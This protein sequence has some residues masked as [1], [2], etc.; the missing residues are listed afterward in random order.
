MAAIFTNFTM[1][2]SLLQLFKYS[3]RIHKDSTFLLSKTEGS[4]KFAKRLGDLAK[5]LEIGA[6]GNCVD[7]N[8][9]SKVSLACGRSY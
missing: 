6:D 9:K 4:K 7:K 3:I 5:N 1:M 8:L 2:I